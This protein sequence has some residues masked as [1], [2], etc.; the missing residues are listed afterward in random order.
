MGRKDPW[1]IS[2]GD[3]RRFVEVGEKMSQKIGIFLVDLLIFWIGSLRIS[4][5]G[6]LGLLIIQILVEAKISGLPSW[7]SP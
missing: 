4:F 1:M 2:L 5:G 7:T 3:L 6:F